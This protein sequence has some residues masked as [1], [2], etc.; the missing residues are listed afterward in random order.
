MQHRQD[1]S[2]STPFQR[3][4]GWTHELL[5][6]VVDGLVGCTSYDI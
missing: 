6:A 2:I 4:G 1:H 3:A 5:G